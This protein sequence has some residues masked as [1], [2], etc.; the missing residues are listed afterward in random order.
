MCAGERCET[1]VSWIGV[2]IFADG[3][4][5][6]RGR[7]NDAF[8]DAADECQRPSGAAE[9]PHHNEIEILV[10]SQRDDAVVRLAM[11][12]T[13]GHRHRARRHCSDK[14]AEQAARDRGCGQCRPCG[15]NRS[16]MCRTGLYAERGI[17]GLDGYQTELVVDREPFIVRVAPEL[18]AVGVLAEPFSVAQKALSEAVHLQLTRLPDMATSLDWLSGKRCLVA[19]LGPIGLLA[20]LSLRLRGAEV[21][22]LDIV[23]ADTARPRWLTLIGG[24]YIDGRQLTPNRP[25]DRTGTF[26]VIVEATG[27]ARLEFDLLDAL[28]MDG[29]YALTGIAGGDRP[30]NVDGSKIMR[31]LVLRNQVLVGSVNASRDHFQRAVDDLALAETRWPHRIVDLIT[32]RHRYSDFDAAFQHHGAD[33]IKVVLEWAA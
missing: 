19:G 32:H 18:E 22:G 2:R 12:Y 15:M 26:D 14:V 28:A 10:T 27:I 24:H 17:W 20:A 9:C 1:T 33:E 8:S 31:R 21:W 13:F 4:N 11:L 16:D 25:I 23:D 7:P 29:V 5:R 30:L 3:E 6:P